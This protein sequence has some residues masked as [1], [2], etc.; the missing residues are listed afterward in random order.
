MKKILLIT[1]ILTLTLGRAFG[2][3]PSFSFNGPTTWVPGSEVTLNVNLTFT[4]FS[5]LGLSYWLETNNAIAP[6]LT[7]KA[8]RCFTFMCNPNSGLFGSFNATS[9]A[10][11]FMATR[12]GFGGT[13]NPPVPPGTYHVTDI[14][15]SVAAG[16]PAGIYTLRSTALSPRVSA[17][18]DSTFGDRN[19]AQSSFI[20]RVTGAPDPLPLAQ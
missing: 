6:F 9:G 15:F 18:T 4:G 16:A 19:I 13:A 14:T 17:M 10:P 5:A 12:D 11:G 3:L 8:V 1:T 7:V 20:F 2:Q